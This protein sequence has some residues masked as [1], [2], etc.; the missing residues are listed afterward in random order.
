MTVRSTKRFARYE[1]KPVGGLT[2]ATYLLATFVR[3]SP[4]HKTAILPFRPVGAFTN[5][6]MMEIN[7]SSLK[8]F[9]R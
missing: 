6:S 1:S 7:C 9:C 8:G 3:L 2:A 5:R 4:D